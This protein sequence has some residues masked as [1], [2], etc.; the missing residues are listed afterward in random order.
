MIENIEEI[1]RRNPW[2]LV[3]PVLAV[4]YLVLRPKGLNVKDKLVLITG[5]SQGIGRGKNCVK[6]GDYLFRNGRACLAVQVCSL[7]WSSTAF[8]H[9]F[10]PPTPL[11][12]QT[13]VAKQLVHKGA[14]VGR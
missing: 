3:A 14:Q 12:N 6:K 10:F 2:T 1:V 4:F 5:G 11:P 7:V 8:I 13:A 9:P